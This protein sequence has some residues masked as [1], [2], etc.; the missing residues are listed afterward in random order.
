MKI[1]RVVLILSASLAFAGSA[2]AALVVT[3][4]F[5]NPGSASF[6]PTAT[7][8][9]ATNSLI[10]SLSPSTQAGNFTAN[11]ATPG[12]SALTDGVIG[13]V[14]GSLNIYANA[15]PSAGTQVIYTLPTAANGYNLTNITVYSGWANGGRSA[16]GYTVL[17]STVANPGSFVYL[18][19]VTYTAGFSGNNPGTPITL[20]VQLTDSAGGAIAANV[21]AIQFDFRFPTAPNGENGGSGYSEITVQGTAAPSVV[22]PVVS[23]TT[24]NE[25]SGST[26]TPSWPIETDSLIAGQLPATS[27]GN[28]INSGVGGLSAVTDGNFGDVGTF[29]NYASCGGSSGTS[30]IYT[31]TNSPNGLDLTNIVVYTG[32]QDNGRFGQYY[33]ISFAPVTAPT[34][35][36]PITTVYYL[37]VIPGSTKVA[38]RVAISTSTGAALGKNVGNVQ[39]DFAGPRNASSF[40]NGWQGYAEIILEGTNSLPPTAPP[41]PYLT[42]DTLPTY[43]E[44]VVGDQVVLT[45]SFSNSPPAN[46]QW[47]V[48]NTNGTATNNIAGATTGTLTLNNVQLSNSGTYR[49]KAVNATNNAG[50]SYSTAIP[51][52]VG[53]SPAAVN[54]IIVNYA[55]QA[56]PSST[57]FF[58]PWTVD[59]T[60]LNLIY[61]F[62]IG[63]GQGTLAYAGDF[64]GGGNYCNA[65]PTILSDGI[66]AS[67]TSLPNLA[68]GAGG[69]LI[70]SGGQVVAY[71][72][73]TNSAPFGLDLTNITVFGGWQDAGRDEQK[74]QVLYSTVQAPASFTP[75]LIADYVPGDPNNQPI[76]T[77]TTVIPATGVLAHNV[78]ILK[79]N[80]N[81]SPGPKNGWEGYSEILVGGK[82]STGFVPSLTSDISPDVAS[83]VVGSQII[84]TAAFSGADS[85][86]WK[87]NGTNILGAT[88]PT[89][90]LN[91]LQLTNAGAY[92]LVASN[93]QGFTG[94]S[95]C[96]VTV[97]PAPT[98]VSNIITAIA[99]QTSQ[100]EVF[101]P[102]WDTNAF[103]SSL[104]YNA[105]PS[106]SGDGD[107]TG[108]TFGVTPTGG[109]LPPVLTDGSF[110][111]IDFNLTGV[112]SWVTCIGSG[113]GVNNAQGGNFVTYA[114][115]ASPNGY[116]ITNIMTAGGW[117]D[118]GRDQQSY[119]V[120]YATAANPTYFTPLAVVSYNPVDPVG[121][122][123]SRATITAASGVL[124]SNVVALE[125]DMTWPG[126]E[127]GFSGYSEIAAYGSPSAT[128]APAGPV[129]TAQH[130]EYTDAFV[131]ETPNLI[132]NQLPSSQGPGVFTNEGCN[133]TNLTDGV[134]GFGAAFAASCG[135]DGTAVSWIIFNSATGWDLTNIVVYTLWNDYGRDGQFYNL[136]YSTWWDPATFLPLASVAYNPPVPH[137]G[138]VTGNRVAIAPPPGQSVLATNVAAVK[139]D[140]TLQ[141]TRDFGWSG[142]SEIVLQGANLALPRLP[143]VNPIT[144]SGGNLI[145]TGT[146]GTPNYSYTWLTTTNLRAPLASWRTNTTGVLDGSGAF[147]NSIPI[148]AAIPA[149]FF[150]LRMP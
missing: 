86:Q 27:V 91:N 136:S 101:T 94:S 38:S 142:Y 71:T 106:V 148:N 110:G 17:Y 96:A 116:D 143:A 87:K 74:Y 132:A 126:G 138:R 28:F 77:R 128:L 83:D 15:G 11:T 149:S 117:N 123:M 104:I 107:F 93:A 53:S 137:D 125:F 31:L 98:V 6:D 75:L 73:I 10:A 25:T 129:I 39:F 88:T 68:F 76:V 19:N 109:S 111:T 89:L 146:G 35:F 54:N 32:W 55:A 102:T 63:S 60:N 121:Y 118:G 64:T 113:T 33:T 130:E 26:F 40:N 37:P 141:G 78:A 51:L 48:I 95:A 100:A 99:T 13:P 147:S 56:F 43:A 2:S 80:W 133:V 103:S 4:D 65:D 57:N 67:M 8:T 62:T 30:V 45:A 12:V 97:N 134:I 150:R 18:T 139:F 105:S 82:P 5:Q 3:G 119:T 112:H 79:I 47:Q 122:S 127:N 69:T 131:V 108:G 85:V 144:V 42:Q 120:N 14:S 23:I 84:I 124:A 24:T 22:S 1:P 49:L 41:S 140:F 52:V 145:F 16:Q 21:A 59:Y 72:L 114:L 135:D 90:T 70:T 92:S 61:G 9:V 7:W 58:P 20:R 34:T 36:T 29:A 50:V 44:T 66:A 46:L 115:P 81:L